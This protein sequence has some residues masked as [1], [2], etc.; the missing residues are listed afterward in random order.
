MAAGTLAEIKKV[1]NSLTADYLFG[2]ANVSDDFE[3]SL[4]KNKENKKNNE[5]KISILGAEGFNLKKINVDI[6]LGKLVSVTGVSG[7]GKS[8]LIVDILGKY[9]SKYFYRTTAL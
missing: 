2:K 6:P 9:L 5:K 1:K 8:T 7:S 3:D 4:R